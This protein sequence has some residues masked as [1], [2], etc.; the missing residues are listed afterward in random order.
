M[1]RYMAIQGETIEELNEIVN[2]MMQ[3]GQWR[4]LGG[5]AVG[6]TYWERYAEIRYTYAQ[7]MIRTNDK[8]QQ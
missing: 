1:E 7:A 2:E 4:P 5:I 8:Q 6:K 3:T